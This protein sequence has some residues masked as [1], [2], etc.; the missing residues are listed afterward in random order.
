MSNLNMSFITREAPA[1]LLKRQHMNSN[2]LRLPA[3]EVM[4]SRGIELLMANLIV[5]R[6]YGHSMLDTIDLEGKLGGKLEETGCP[7]P[8]QLQKIELKNLLPTV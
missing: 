7:K 3:A 4:F 6:T 2:V 5:I 1:V 8:E